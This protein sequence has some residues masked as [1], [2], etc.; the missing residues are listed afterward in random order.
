MFTKGYKVE[1]K[2]MIKVKSWKVRLQKIIKS[3]E[4]I[5]LKKRTSYAPSLKK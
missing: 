2:E 5:S 1:K 4:E 3:I